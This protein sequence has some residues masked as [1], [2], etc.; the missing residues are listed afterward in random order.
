MSN[1]A[2][3]FEFKLDDFDLDLLPIATDLVKANRELRE[4]A[5]SL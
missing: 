5:V 2:L 4:K 3:I 1:E